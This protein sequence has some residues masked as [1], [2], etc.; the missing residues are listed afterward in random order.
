MEN[1]ITVTARET[2][3]VFKRVQDR[4]IRF[5]RRQGNSVLQRL[6][7][8]IKYAFHKCGMKNKIV[9][10]DL[11]LLQNYPFL[12]RFPKISRILQ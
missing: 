3:S 11:I 7:Y 2:E 8:P 12:R 6:I 4:T 5:D 1:Q 10:I 9:I